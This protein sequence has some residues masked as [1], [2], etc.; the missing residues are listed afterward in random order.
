MAEG[1]LICHRDGD[2]MVAQYGPVVSANDVVTF[3]SIVFLIA[4][5]ED[6]F[7]LDALS[8][9]RGRAYVPM[10]ISIV[11]QRRPRTSN[12]HLPAPLKIEGKS[13]IPTYKGVGTQSQ[14]M[15]IGVIIFSSSAE[16]RLKDITRG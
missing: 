10:C 1:R 4:R 7:L 14:D 8:K 2:Y 5:K 3:G 9:Q 12:K 16:N 15:T 6:K 11:R 13:V